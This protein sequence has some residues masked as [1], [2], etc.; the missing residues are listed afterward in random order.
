MKKII[1]EIYIN[2]GITLIALVIT[3]IILLI[4]S[5]IGIEILSGSN[6][7][8]T[9][10]EEAIYKQKLSAYKEQVNMY[11]MEKYTSDV[12]FDKNKFN[13]DKNM[14]SYT[15]EQEEVTIS[16]LRD[17]IAT[18]TDDDCDK[19]II[20]NGKLKILEDVDEN[21]IKWSN[22]MGIETKY[23]SIKAKII[24]IQSS[25]IIVEI[26][27]PSVLSINYLNMKD[28]VNNYLVKY[29]NIDYE[30]N[31]ME[32]NA[33]I[34]TEY[35]ILICSSGRY[36]SAK[37]KIDSNRIGGEGVTINEPEEKYYGFGSGNK[38]YYKKLSGNQT[39]SNVTFGDPCPGVPKASYVVGNNVSVYETKLSKIMDTYLLDT[40]NAIFNVDNY[41]DDKFNISFNGYGMEEIKSAKIYKNE[42]IVS[43]GSINNNKFSITSQFEDDESYIFELIFNGDYKYIRALKLKKDVGVEERKLGEEG[44]RINTEGKWYYIKFGK[45]TRWKYKWIYGSNVTITG[46]FMGGDPALGVRKDVYLVDSAEFTD[47][48]E[49]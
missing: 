15:L 6:G 28:S 5:G 36:F 25:K 20:E 23:F 49:R 21:E 37:F 7:M 46:A 1:R 34:N 27:L 32:I 24:E 30:N 4:I 48:I 18:I 16:G 19:F 9:K 3:I 8:I 2:S 39:I 33:Q 35:D 26:E 42:D 47:L 22:D 12:N 29:E 11:I 38:Y 14:G 17:V 44:V 41:E 40:T 45:D 31:K 13:A 10:S 43:E